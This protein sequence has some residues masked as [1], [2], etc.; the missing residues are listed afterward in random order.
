VF[1]PYARGNT[2]FFAWAF[3]WVCAYVREYPS[4]RQQWCHRKFLLLS[5]R[6]GDCLGWRSDGL[7]YMP[8]FFI[9]PR[10]SVLSTA[11]YGRIHPGICSLTS[12]QARADISIR[13]SNFSRVELAGLTAGQRI[14]G[15]MLAEAG[16]GTDVL[17]IKWVAR[18]V[19]AWLLV[20][21]RR[22]N[23]MRPIPRICTCLWQGLPPIRKEPPLRLN[24]AALEMPGTGLPDAYWQR[25]NHT[26]IL[27]SRR[28]FRRQLW[29]TS[30][31]LFAS[32]ECPVGPVPDLSPLGIFSHQSVA[33]LGSAACHSPLETV[34]RSGPSWGG[35]SGCTA[36]TKNL[37]APINNLQNI[38][39]RHADQTGV[40]WS[41]VMT[42]NHS[43]KHCYDWQRALSVNGLVCIR[44]KRK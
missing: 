3:S 33:T 43:Q 39:G 12:W 40:L 2:F 26:E 21:S 10:G 13:E 41:N 36:P 7:I 29:S 19:G 42:S 31:L 27:A 20:L 30:V 1:S 28:N 24:Y 44:F 15:S 37:G 32:L 5:G 17:F 34:I 16:R 11:S 9:L 6:T 4:L 35:L 8:L 23:L 18:A 14:V 38:K 25:P 22:Q